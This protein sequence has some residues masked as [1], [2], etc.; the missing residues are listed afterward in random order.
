MLQIGAWIFLLGSLV[1]A[2]LPTASHQSTN[3][4]LDDSITIDSL[5]GQ[6]CNNITIHSYVEQCCVEYIPLRATPA[7]HSKQVKHEKA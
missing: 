2:K 3:Y 7:V 6:L 5:I 4:I 1:E